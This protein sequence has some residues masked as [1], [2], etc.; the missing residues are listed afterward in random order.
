M[1]NETTESYGNP[2]ATKEQ[3]ELEQSQGG[4]EQ[5][6]RGVTDPFQNRENG[7]AEFDT[8]DSVQNLSVDTWGPTWQVLNKNNLFHSCIS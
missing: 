4:L 1:G 7:N 3:G 5:C 6:K 8:F 2:L